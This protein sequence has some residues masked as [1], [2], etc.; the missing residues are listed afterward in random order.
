MSALLTSSALNTP[1]S[2]VVPVLAK[3]GARS[4]LIIVQPGESPAHVIY[5]LPA[6]GVPAKHY[7][8]LAEA[9]AKH[10]MAMALHEWRGLGSSDRRAG[11]QCDWGYR[12]LLEADVPAGIAEARARWPRATLWIA[13]HSLG[14]QLSCLYA[15]LHPDTVAGI[16]LI[17][18]GSPYWRRFRFGALLSIAYRLASP[19]A[20]LVGYL[21]GRRLGFGGNEA[22]GV[23]A[24]WS[25]SGRTGCYSADGMAVD[26]ERQ[27]RALAMPVFALRLR[28][29]WLAPQSSLAWL[30]DKMP[31][32]FQRMDVMTPERMDGQAADHFSWMKFPYA[33]VA[34][35]SE[36]IQRSEA[37]RGSLESAGS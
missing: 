1:S 30:L 4:E 10:G 31:K 19:L 22:R 32:T 21:P 12:E 23:I 14:G 8:P 36:W 6:L 13:G 18:S 29:D 28:D 3:D 25:R 5:W 33:L 35:L 34:Q 2:T 15:S 16:M 37:V 27:L 20:Q 26:F 9:F 7:L 17:G 11:R 24:D